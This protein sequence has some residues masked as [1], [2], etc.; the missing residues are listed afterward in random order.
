[1]SAD[2]QHE[3]EGETTPD[4]LMTAGDQRQP[5]KFN[6]FEEGVHAAIQT[7][8]HWEL[9]PCAPHDA[10]CSYEKKQRI[11]KVNFSDASTEVPDKEAAEQ[12]HDDHD[13]V[14]DG[15]NRASKGIDMDNDITGESIQELRNDL[16]SK[17]A[18]IIQWRRT[19]MSMLDHYESVIHSSP[20]SEDKEELLQQVS[21]ERTGA[22]A[23]C[24]Q[25]LREIDALL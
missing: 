8:S 19:R 16:T 23:H 13:D 7:D 2:K 15:S 21:D 24:S 10:F 14:E 20:H 6:M 12:Q 5:E 22:E 9:L 18:T 25:Q 4:S 11:L 3:S 1:M 17:R